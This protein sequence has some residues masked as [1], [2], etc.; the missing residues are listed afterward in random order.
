[1]R[2]DVV[3]VLRNTRLRVV[4]RVAESIGSRRL[5]VDEGPTIEVGRETG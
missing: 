1:M 3:S 5:A 2:L 4:L